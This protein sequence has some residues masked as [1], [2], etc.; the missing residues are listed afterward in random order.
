M[1]LRGVRPLYDDGSADPSGGHARLR[2]E[3]GRRKGARAA[4]VGLRRQDHHL[5]APGRARDGEARAVLSRDSGRPGRRASRCP[6]ATWRD[7]NAFRDELRGAYMG[8]P[9]EWLEGVARRHG[10]LSATV[11]GEAKTPE[12]PRRALRRRAHRSAKCDYMV[13]HEWARTAD[14]VLWRRSK[15]GLHMT[16]EQRAAVAAYSLRAQVSEARLKPLSA[17]SRRS[18]RAHPGVFCRHRRHAHQRRRL[19]GAT[20]MWRWNACAPPG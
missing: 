5:P 7:F 11:L 14:D 1:E 16:P 10:T 6:G 19:P 18:R 8:L 12:R 4:A 9:R 13:E 17:F 3:A 15:C 2:A 20:P